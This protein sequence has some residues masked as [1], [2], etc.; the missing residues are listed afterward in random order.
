M[1]VFGD[2]DICAILVVVYSD[3]ICVLLVIATVMTFVCYMNY[4]LVMG[5]AQKEAETSS[6]VVP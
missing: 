5:V 6:E 1:C 4:E 2:G 3:G